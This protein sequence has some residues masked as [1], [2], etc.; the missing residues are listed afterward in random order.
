MGAGSCGRGVGGVGFQG[1]DLA[2]VLVAQLLDAGGELGR[3]VLGADPRIVRV[4][5]PPGGA[6]E[7]DDK[8]QAGQDLAKRPGEN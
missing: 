5:Q 4:H 6:G 2:R 1:C 3:L 7:G 8:R